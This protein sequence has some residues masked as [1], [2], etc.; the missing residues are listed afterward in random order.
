MQVE[1]SDLVVETKTENEQHINQIQALETECSRLKQQTKEI[2]TKAVKNAQQ[3]QDVQLDT[4]TTAE[5][6]K[7]RTKVEHFEA[8]ESELKTQLVTATRRNQ[9]AASQVQAL[10]VKRY[11]MTGDEG[12]DGRYELSATLKKQ[13]YS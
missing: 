7:L 12:P 10:L 6:D 5:N 3:K 9:E 2:E 8:R 11:K 1:K 4:T 13:G